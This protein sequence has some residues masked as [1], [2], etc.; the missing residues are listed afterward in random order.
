LPDALRDQNVRIGGMEGKRVLI[1]ISA[2]LQTGE[3]ADF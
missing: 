2:C 3:E 1:P